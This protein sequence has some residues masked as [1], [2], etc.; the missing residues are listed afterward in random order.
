MWVFDT[1]EVGEG[2]G[3]TY[4][5]GCNRRTARTTKERL[6]LDQAGRPSGEDLPADVPFSLFN[7]FFVA[8]LACEG[9]V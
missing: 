7:R 5:G 6:L 1:E 2:E 4:D 8:L 3:A 9:V